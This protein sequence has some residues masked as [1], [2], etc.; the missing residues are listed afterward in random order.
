MQVS[1][2][3][4]QD[5]PAE[6][7]YSFIKRA[8]LD[9][10]GADAIYILGSPWDALGMIA[11]LEQDLGVPVVEPVAARIWEIQRHVRQPIKGYGTL[12]ETLPA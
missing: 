8:F 1:F 10:T 12:L 3:S 5:V 4:I 2:R 9:H 6:A 7:M 11:T